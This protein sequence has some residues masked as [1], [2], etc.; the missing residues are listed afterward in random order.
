MIVVGRTRLAELY[1][2][3]EGLYTRVVE[4][5]TGRLGLPKD[6]KDLVG[7]KQGLR[8]RLGYFRFPYLCRC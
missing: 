7:A 5:A 3:R 6:A 8:R 2:V 4:V 1:E